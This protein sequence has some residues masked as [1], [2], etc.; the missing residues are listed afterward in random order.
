MNDP[1][2]VLTYPKHFLLTVLTIRSYLRHNTASEITVLVDDTDKHCWPSYLEDCAKYY[3]TLHPQLKVVPVSQWELHKRFSGPWD[4][5]IRQQFLKL[6][7]DQVVSYTKWM[8]TDG[9]M[10]YINPVPRD[11]I[12]FSIVAP[13][14][15]FQSDSNQWC[16]LMLKTDSVG[17]FLYHPDMH[18]FARPGEEHQV[19]V[20]NPPCRT[21]TA[22]TLVDLR[23]YVEK[24]HGCNIV[25][26]NFK[27]HAETNGNAGVQSEWELIANFQHK[28]QNNPVP[29][30]FYPTYPIERVHT[31]VDRYPFCGTTFEPEN[32]TR[33]WFVEYGIECDNSVWNNIQTFIAN[34]R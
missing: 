4:S 16:R 8:F 27:V 1:L 33:E 18:A 12:P 11:A 20:S 9:D 25:D 28:I 22:S 24:V 29:L 23:A 17:F 32:F 5:W 13:G 31:T 15:Q 14:G 3:S 26:A 34:T 7:L 21:M 2:V 30:E 19:C 6:H 10:Y